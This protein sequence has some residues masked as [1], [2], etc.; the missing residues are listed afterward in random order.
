MTQSKLRYNTTCLQNRQIWCNGSIEIDN[1]VYQTNNNVQPKDKLNI[2]IEEMKTLMLKESQKIPIE[3]RKSK[4]NNKIHLIA[5]I[6]ISKKGGQLHHKVWKP[7][8]QEK[9]AT[10]HQQHNK[11]HD[12]R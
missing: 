12:Q 10:E 1:K 8:R 5:Q 11:V 3:Q 9:I 7:G 2:K 4:D 6:Y